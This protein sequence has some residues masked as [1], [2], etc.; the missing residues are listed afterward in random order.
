MH[1]DYNGH[2]LLSCKYDSTRYEQPTRVKLLNK[3]QN[4]ENLNWKK[5]RLAIVLSNCMLFIKENV[6]TFFY[7]SNGIFYSVMSI[8]SENLIIAFTKIMTI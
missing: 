8:T 4:Y 6:I 1:N 7:V 3:T 5:K 2:L